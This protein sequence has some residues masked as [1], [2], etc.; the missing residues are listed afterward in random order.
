[1]LSPTKVRYQVNRAI[2]VF[3]PAGEERARLVIHYDKATSVKRIS[4]EVY[5]EAG[6]QLRKFTKRDCRDESAVSN[7]SLYE[8]S[9]VKHFLPAMAGYPYTV[10]YSY[11][12]ERKQNLII[13]AWRPDAYWDVA[14][15]HSQYTFICADTDEVR[16]IVT[17]YTGEPVHHVDGGRSATTWVAD[18]LPARRY[19]PYRPD[20]E[21]YQ[22]TVRIHPLPLDYYNHNGQYT[23]WEE[24]GS[25]MFDALISEG[26][27]H[28][29]QT[30]AEVKELVAGLASD[31]ERSEER[32]VGKECGS[33][34]RSRGT[35]YH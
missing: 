12:V 2:T 11:E 26:M 27:E 16:I 3:N 15:H 30:V 10:V 25:W 6:F 19:E 29:A 35:P 21:T 8:D 17:N 5:D 34:C 31:K 14:V 22:T 32:R 20:P 24:L 18:N 28:P 1:M 33:T 4:G 23:N 7:F 13:P 9:R